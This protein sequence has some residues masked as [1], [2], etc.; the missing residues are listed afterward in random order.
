MKSERKRIVNIFIILFM[1]IILYILIQNV[2]YIKDYEALTPTGNID[3]FEISCACYCE[4]GEQEVVPNTGSIEPEERI[5]DLGDLIVYDDEKIWDNQDLR[6][7]TNPIYD[8]KSIIA[9]GSHN[10]YAFIIKNNNNF[11]LMIDIAFN[12]TNYKDINMQFKLKNE[13]KYLL[14]SERN[15][16]KISGKK[17]EDIWLPANGQKEYVLDWKWIDSNNDAEVGFDIYSFYKLSIIVMAN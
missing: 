2:G 17:I 15:Y 6:I 5:P 8:N 10:S 1:L 14:G 11:D 9:P 16:E 12:E 4:S 7:F 13:D 3:I